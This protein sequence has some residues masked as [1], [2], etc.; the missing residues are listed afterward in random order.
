MR[1]KTLQLAGR[2]LTRVVLSAGI[3][4]LSRLSQYADKS[5]VAGVAWKSSA[6]GSFPDM[7]NRLPMDRHQSSADKSTGSG[8]A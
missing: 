5:T 1:C 8:I 7:W 6:A 3:N 4:A 2:D